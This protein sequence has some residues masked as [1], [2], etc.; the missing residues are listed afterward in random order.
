MPRV[1]SQ[2]AR[3]DYPAEGIVAGDIYYK[4]TLRPGG[5]GRGRLYRSSS[6]PKPWQLTSS[7]YLQEVYM[8]QDRVASLEFSDSIESELGEIIGELEGVRDQCQESLDNMPESLQ[9][10]PTG[11][12]LQERIENMESAIQELESHQG[13]EPSRDDFE[14]DEEMDDAVESYMSGVNETGVEA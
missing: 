4:W 14:T 8:I 13:S 9:S 3:K 1:H 11:E 2:K 10:S 6:Y 12:L 7:P 5:R